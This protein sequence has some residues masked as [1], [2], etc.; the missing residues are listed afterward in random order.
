V[1]VLAAARVVT[2][3]EVHAPGWI[4]Y[5]ADRIVAAGS[6]RP[7]N[8]DRDLGEAVV[9]P[10]FVDMHVHGGGG[11]SFTGDVTSALQTVQTHRLHGTTTT[12]ASLVTAGPDQLIASVSMLAELFEAGVVA[13]IHLEGPWI[14]AHRR[15]AH[16]PTQLRDPD[17]AEIGRLLAVGRGAIQMVTLAP[18]LPGALDAVRQI[19]DAGAVAAIGHTDASYEQV[20]QAIAAGAR[21]GT[22]LFNAMR[23]LHHRQPGPI[24]ALLDDPR[25]TVELIADGIHLHPALYHHTSNTTDPDRVA[26]VT[27]AMAAAALGDGPYQLGPLQVSVANGIA[28]I[29]G[30]N[31][32]AGSTTTMDQLFK[33]ATTHASILH[34]GSVESPGYATDEALLRAARQTSVNPARTLG[35]TNTGGLQPGKRTDLVILDPTLNL[36]DVIRGGISIEGQRPRTT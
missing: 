13:G 3:H 23:P 12:M 25:V 18:E 33:T 7:A 24:V 36:T 27:D 9:V 32:I 20:V 14:S 29:T 19:V 35:W 11:G 26:L 28:H 30:T 22:H 8:V 10:G 16:D 5:D 4:E 2:G 1:T 21:V 17:P 31:T 15:G 34:P 6:G